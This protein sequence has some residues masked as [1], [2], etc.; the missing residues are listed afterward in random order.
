MKLKRSLPSVKLQD[1]QQIHNA[2]IRIG[3]NSKQIQKNM[4]SQM[5]QNN[6]S[7]KMIKYEES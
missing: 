7:E 5:N 1:M 2:V 3:A 6:W 4:L